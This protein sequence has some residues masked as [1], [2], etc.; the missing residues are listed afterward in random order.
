MSSS[1]SVPGGIPEETIELPALALVVIM[2]VPAQARASLS[3]RLF[4][5]QE[6]CAS[7][8]AA[9]ERLIHGQLAVLE[10]PYLHAH[11]RAELVALAHAYEVEASA[12]V[13]DLAPEGA[14]GA[15]R[16]ASAALRAGLGGADSP[17]LR[18][19]GFASV[20]R[21]RSQ[22]ALEAVQ[23]AL[24]PLKPDRRELIGP[25]DLIGDVHGCLTELR[26]LLQK[27]GY[28]VTDAL[29]VIAPPGRTAVFLGDLVDRGPDSAGVLRLVMGMAA[30]GTALCV[31]GNHDAKLRRALTGHRVGRTHGLEVTLDQ[32]AEQPP[33]F[34][35]QVSDFLA[36]LPHHLVLDGGRLV[37]AHA[38]L[39][40]R[41]QGRDSGRVRAF[42]LYGDTERSQDDDGPPLRRDWAAEYHG[43]A[44]V[45]YGHTPVPRPRWKHQTVNLDTGC[46]FGGALSALRYPELETSSVKAGAVYREAAW[47]FLND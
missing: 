10:G 44:L 42:A 8:R 4:G 47:P 41:F 13:L 31:C 20:R 15:A 11:E 18:V 12:L 34:S 3:A 38:G 36:A 26:E 32:L 39:P 45:A 22:A 2:G 43:A 33:E 40:Q 28:Q 9:Q 1:D 46:V 25:F 29:E 23:L 27:L 35:V 16:Q 37:A 24:V 6:R 17:A 5:P 21:L 7:L 14:D 30:A 19:E